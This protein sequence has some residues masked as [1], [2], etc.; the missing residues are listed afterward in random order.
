MNRIFA[1]I[2]APNLSKH[3]VRMIPS[4]RLERGFVSNSGAV[5]AGLCFFGG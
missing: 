4:V 2:T 5:N 3:C 1:T